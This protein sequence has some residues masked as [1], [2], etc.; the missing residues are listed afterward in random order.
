MNSILVFDIETVPDV[1]SGARVYDLPEDADMDDGDIAELMF[2]RRRQESNGRSEFLR[3]H[4]Q[5]LVAISVLLRQQG[6]KIELFSLGEPDDDEQTLLRCFF[7]LVEEHTPTLVSW[8]GSGFD[9]PVLHY[10]ALLHGVPCARY[11]EDGS[12][13]ADFRWNNY[14]N[15]YHSRH[16]DLMSVLSG[17]QSFAFASLNEIA[18][19]LGLPGK[20]L[21]DGGAVWQCYQRNDLA[22]IRDYCEIDV[23]NT[24]L[25]YLRYQLLR[26]RLNPQRHADECD[27]V[28]AALGEGSAQHLQDFLR[29]WR[30]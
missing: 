30:G 15:R 28:A 2:S 25:I 12:R 7:D 29:A 17:Q 10:R 14:L 19:M 3:H 22:T 24:Y 11:W 16:T 9:L 23:L 13:D 27:R 18:I 20:M 21:L 26:A 6:Q 8:N 5:K 4:L 1:R